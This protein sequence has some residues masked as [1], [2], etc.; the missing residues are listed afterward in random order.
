MYYNNHAHGIL[1]FCV[2]CSSQT[3]ETLTA[4]R[5]K[6]AQM[7]FKICAI[8]HQGTQHKCMPAIAGTYAL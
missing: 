1:D 6:E 2:L 5:M 4:S 8:F 7:V 3:N